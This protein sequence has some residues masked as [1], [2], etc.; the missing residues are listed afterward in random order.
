MS[1]DTLFHQLT[2]PDRPFYHY[3][4]YWLLCWVSWVYALIQRARAIGYER[5]LLRAR[6]LP[7]PVIS[8]GNLTLGGTGKTPTV[9][10]LAETLQKMGHRPAILSRGYGGEAIEPVNVVS[11]GETVL[12]DV[13]EA[14]D[15]PVLLANRLPGVPVLTGRRRSALKP[16]T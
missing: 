13:K 8:V 14:G 5:G 9:M 2:S 6:R 11:D 3:P 1:L 10:W 12:M 16:A 7:V 4:T 15:E